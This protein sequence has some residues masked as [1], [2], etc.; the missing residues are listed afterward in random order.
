M[1]SA[2]MR[3]LV[4][5]VWLSV[6]ACSGSNRREEGPRAPT[7]THDDGQPVADPQTGTVG[8]DGHPTRAECEE[9]LDHTLSVLL[10][11]MR[12]TQ[13]PETI[14]TDDQVDKIRLAMRETELESC[15][16]GDRE[17]LRCG[18]R[19]QTVDAMRACEAAARGGSARR[20]GA[21]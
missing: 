20:P 5:V 3:A 21:P 7:P 16:L 4:V 15:L 13:D 11:H 10:E 8:P 18:L 19:A 17:L 1:I 14:P 9:L 6:L 2:M 12:A